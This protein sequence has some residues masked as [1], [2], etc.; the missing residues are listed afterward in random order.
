VLNELEWKWQDTNQI[1]AVGELNFL[2]T[3]K[4]VINSSIHLSIGY[5]VI[6]PTNGHW[7]TMAALNQ[8]WTG[9]WDKEKMARLL[10]L[11]GPCQVMDMHISDF[12]TVC[13]CAVFS[14]CYFPFTGKKKPL[15][16]STHPQGAQPA[17]SP[18]AKGT[19]RTH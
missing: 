7:A 6:Y 12:L 5:P 19:R 8:T 9:F 11:G 2:Q 16:A 4:E 3:Q 18:L 13:V 1:E 17:T 15:L 14:F 10:Y